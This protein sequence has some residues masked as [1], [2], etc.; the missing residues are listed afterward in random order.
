MR[1]RDPLKITGRLLLASGALFLGGVSMN[2]AAERGLAD[3]THLSAEGLNGLGDG[4][5]A[6]G[7]L[8]TVSMGGEYLAERDRKRRIDHEAELGELRVKNYN[9]PAEILHEKLPPVANAQFAAKKLR[10]F[11]LNPERVVRDRLEQSIFRKQTTYNF[12]MSAIE[13]G[14]PVSAAEWEECD[15]ETIAA[16]IWSPLVSRKIHWDEHGVVDEIEAGELLWKSVNAATS[17][18]VE[19]PGKQSYIGWASIL[20]DELA[21]LDQT[22]VT[23]PGCSDGKHW[24]DVIENMAVERAGS[25]AALFDK[26]L[27]RETA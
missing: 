13:A 9:M 26:I 12:I 18:M 16:T 10:H 22:V 3:K 27:V 6:L 23:T 2:I 21:P 1:E 25:R 11:Q 7:F 8:G 19:K 15:M 24:S 5:A 17:L 14:I 20:L 4:L